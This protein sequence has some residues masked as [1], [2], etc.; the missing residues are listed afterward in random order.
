MTTVQCSE[1]RYVQL[2][3]RCKTGVLTHAEQQELQDLAQQKLFGMFKSDPSL[4]AV[5]KRL[6]DR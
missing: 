3:T 1:K 2:Q 4:L 5:F 6:K